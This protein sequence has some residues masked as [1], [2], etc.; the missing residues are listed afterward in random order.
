MTSGTGSCG[1]TASWAADANYSAATASQS[2][3]AA[4]AAS[5]T[6]IASPA[7][8][9]SVV[10]QAVTVGFSVTGSGVAPTGTVTVTASTK[11]TCSGTL[12][13]SSCALTFVT[14]GTRTMTATYSG[15]S[16]YLGSTSGA[17]AAE[18]VLDFVLGI[19]PGTQT[20]NGGQRAA[21]TLTATAIGGVSMPITLSCTINPVYTCTVMP[22]SVTPNGGTKNATI[23]VNTVKGF[24]GNYTLTVTGVDTQTGFTL[25]HTVTAGLT[26][27]K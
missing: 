21:Y 1:L 22:T 26:V 23:Y 9:P 13:A 8:I 6:T 7:P 11:E 18:N 20:V 17:S 14:T 15:D 4:K 2:I 10:G 27:N 12:P 19:K 5:A 25:T 3:A 24:G 16:N